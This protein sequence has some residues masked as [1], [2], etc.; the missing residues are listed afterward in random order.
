MKFVGL[1]RGYISQT[2]KTKLVVFNLPNAMKTISQVVE[3]LN[4]KKLFLLPLHN[5]NSP[6]VMNHNLNTFQDRSLQPRG[7]KSTG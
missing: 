1:L 2:E 3:T 6:T 7:L 5:C 4:H